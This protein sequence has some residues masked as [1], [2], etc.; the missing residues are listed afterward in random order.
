MKQSIC[1]QCFNP[2]DGYTTYI[3]LQRG[4]FKATYQLQVCWNCFEIYREMAHST[5]TRWLRLQPAQQVKLPLK[6]LE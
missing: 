5:A 1:G 2:T 3:G 4:T 6:L